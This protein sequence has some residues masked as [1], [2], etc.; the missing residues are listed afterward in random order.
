METAAVVS[1]HAPWC[2]RDHARGQCS[3]K[4]G[5]WDRSTNTWDSDLTVEDRRVMAKALDMWRREGHSLQETGDWLRTHKTFEKVANGVLLT[6]NMTQ[7][8]Y[9][10]KG[11]SWPI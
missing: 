11:K 6:W 4:R 10:K 2:V 5:H 8:K 9:E 7:K 3:E 1:E